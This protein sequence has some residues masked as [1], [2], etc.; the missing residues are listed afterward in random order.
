MID[1]PKDIDLLHHQVAKFTAELQ[2]LRQQTESL[3]AELEQ[4]RG[5]R[6]SLRGR[7]ALYDAAKENAVDSWKLIAQETT[8]RE[9]L[10]KIAKVVRI[11]QQ[12]LQEESKEDMVLV[13]REPTEEMIEAGWK[14]RLG[15]VFGER[16]G[17]VA[18]YKA[19]IAAT[20]NVQGDTK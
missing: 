5:D 18:I 17:I 15:S 16:R 6:N 19:M 12:A 14:G 4:M 2:E 20:N 13:P 7:L 3:Q 8:L 9:A 11:A 1:T 10:E